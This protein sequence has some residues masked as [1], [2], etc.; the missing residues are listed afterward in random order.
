MKLE[1]IG[2]DRTPVSCSLYEGAKIVKLRAFLCLI[3]NLFL[4]GLKEVSCC[5]VLSSLITGGYE[6]NFRAC[7]V[8]ADV[9][10]VVVTAESE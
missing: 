10:V 3:D 8:G 5:G 1:L 6:C 4:V 9:D 2:A 7:F